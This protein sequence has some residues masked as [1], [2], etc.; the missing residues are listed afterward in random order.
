MVALTL[1]STIGSSFDFLWSN[2]SGRHLL[3][4]LTLTSDLIVALDQLV[5]RTAG[6]P[7]MHD[8]L[9][10]RCWVQHQ[11]LAFTP[12]SSD[13][14][15]YQQ[16]IL[17]VCRLSAL[18]FSEMVIFPFPAVQKIKPMLAERL[19][20][21]LLDLLETSVETS[22]QRLL[23]WATVMGSIAST[24]NEH[25][26]WFLEQL[27]QSL[28]DIDVQ[29]WEGLRELCASF[30]WWDPVC[31]PPALAVW[32]EAKLIVTYSPEQRSRFPV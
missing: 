11:F 12:D 17:T 28:V 8:L 14:D 13:E 23:T 25:H 30:L 2:G 18:I 27:I 24:Y 5:R 16:R 20:D 3:E 4:I 15:D 9:P 19:R 6:A 22:H 21:A 32:K 29:S 31:T 10:S 7:H 1:N 26:E